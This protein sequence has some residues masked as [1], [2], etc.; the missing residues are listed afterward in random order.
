V[1]VVKIVAGIA[2]AEAEIAEV[3][4]DW[5]LEVGRGVTLQA[6]ANQRQFTGT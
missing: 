2:R 4:G 3:P 6:A 5:S 1:R